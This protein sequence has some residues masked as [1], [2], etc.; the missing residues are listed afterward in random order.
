MLSLLLISLMVLGSSC[1]T[2]VPEHTTEVILEPLPPQPIIVEITPLLIGFPDIPV[3]PEV[4]FNASS[5]QKAP[6][7]T[8]VEYVWL[9]ITDA[10]LLASYLVEVGA[11]TE[12]IEVI[13]GYQK[14][15]FNDTVNSGGG[16]GS[17]PD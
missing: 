5:I 10:Q 2:P 12:K 1:A 16:G 8:H 4:T 13:D 7:T 17:P 6:L 3:Y 14:D 15:V 11:Y 9:S